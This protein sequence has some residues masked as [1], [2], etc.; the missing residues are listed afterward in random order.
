[1]ALQVKA[2]EKRG[3]WIWLN[4]HNEPWEADDSAFWGASL[5]GIAAG[6]APETY[7]KSAEVQE[8]IAMLGEYLQREQQ[9]QSTLNR[10]VALWASGKLPQLL[11]PGQRAAI[12]AKSPA[13]SGPTVG[14]ANR[15]S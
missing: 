12:V 5:A 10:A 6:W 4:F 13:S 3:S 14:G 9:N 1:M 8:N 15:R 11:N 7:R 2:G